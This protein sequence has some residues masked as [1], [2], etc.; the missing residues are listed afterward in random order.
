ME[1]LLEN[2]HKVLSEIAR[3]DD[4]LNDKAGV[5]QVLKLTGKLETLM[6]QKFTAVSNKV[7]EIVP[8]LETEN[9]ADNS[10]NINTNLNDCVQQVMATQNTVE[11]KLDKLAETVEKQKI[12]EGHCVLD[13]VE[14]VVRSKFREDKEEEEEIDKRK[15][16]IIVH[17]LKESTDCDAEARKKSDESDIINMLHEIKCDEVSVVNAIR[18]GKRDE[19]AAKPRPL[20]IVVSSEDQ[21][22]K[23]L[24]MAKNLRRTKNKGLEGVFLHQDLTPKQ[25]GER[26]RLVKEME[27]RMKAGEK[28]LIIVNWKIVALKKKK[29]AGKEEVDPVTERTDPEIAC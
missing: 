17:G 16:S 3:L 7:G 27:N 12:L 10:N 20:K 2:V 1:D 8:H 5:D 25:R 4:K 22:I 28:D 6:E 11:N 21:K 18:L 13:R 29:T 23:V 14:D 24:Q 26:Q 15:T 9:A 19:T